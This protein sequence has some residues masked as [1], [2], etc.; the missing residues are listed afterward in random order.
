M[1]LVSLNKHFGQ[2]TKL[3]LSRGLCKITTRAGLDLGRRISTNILSVLTQRLVFRL[4][5][6]KF[7]TKQAIPP[8]QDRSDP[9]VIG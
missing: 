6:I 5:E 8:L 9:T 2:F 1:A 7:L 3:Y 4:Y